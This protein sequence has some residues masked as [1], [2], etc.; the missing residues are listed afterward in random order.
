M[1]MPWDGISWNDTAWLDSIFYG[2]NEDLVRFLKFNKKTIEDNC[3]TFLGR[4]FDLLIAEPGVDLR[5]STDC[6]RS[7]LVT[8]G[9]DVQ[10]ENDF[11][12]EVL[13]SFPI[14]KSV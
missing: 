2:F 12:I 4:P 6:L 8:A 14:F 13:S 7:N 5:C 3:T 10:L 11:C 1:C 9:F